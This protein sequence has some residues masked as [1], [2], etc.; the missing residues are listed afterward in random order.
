MEDLESSGTK[1]SLNGPIVHKL[2][3]EEGGKR[4][5]SLDEFQGFFHTFYILVCH[6]T[7]LAKD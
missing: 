6:F 3:K 2:C 4:W 7:T 1:A 5:Q